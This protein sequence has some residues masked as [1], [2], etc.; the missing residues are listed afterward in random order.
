MFVGVL[1][2]YRDNILKLY[3]RL[4]WR[5]YEL[6]LP[7]GTKPDAMTGHL[8]DYLQRIDKPQE[9]YWLRFKDEIGRFFSSADHLRFEHG[10]RCWTKY[11][12]PI[13]RSYSA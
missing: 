4:N 2:L 10:S 7:Y 13:R 3:V 9:D 11:R 12:T 1:D 6:S 8:D 5:A